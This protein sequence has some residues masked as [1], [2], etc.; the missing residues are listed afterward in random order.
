MENQKSCEDFLLS[1][2]L[3]QVLSSRFQELVMLDQ[4]HSSLL[5]LKGQ[6][7]HMNQEQIAPL[8]WTSWSDPDMAEW[9]QTLVVGETGTGI[10][11]GSGSGSGSDSGSG[12]G[13]G[14]GSGSDSD[15]VD[16]A[17]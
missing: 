10:G 4:D 6:A 7:N 16:I 17:A 1:S 11:S 5:H 13:F 9:Q 2:N 12:F 8:A 14:F 3:T 15:V